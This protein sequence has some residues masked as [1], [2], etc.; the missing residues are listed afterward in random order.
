DDV[1]PR[2]L[3]AAL[4]QPG[5]QLL[6]LLDR[7]ETRRQVSNQRGAVLRPAGRE[8]VSEAHSAS[9]CGLSPKYSAA[10]SMSL[11]PRPERFTR[12]AAPLPSSWPSCSAPAKACAD[13]MAGM[14]PSLL[15]SRRKARIAS[16]SVTA[17]YSAR[18]MSLR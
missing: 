3:R 10:V 2:A 9:S 11:S 18:P 4:D 13:S 14:M 16:S 8:N 6:G 15:D 12:T 17:R 5:E 7:R 1:A